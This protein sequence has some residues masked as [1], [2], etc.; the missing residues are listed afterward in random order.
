VYDLFCKNVEYKSL[1]EEGFLK[2]AIIGENLKGDGMSLNQSVKRY[3]DVL[4]EFI[5]KVSLRNSS[6]PDM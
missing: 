1:I 2:I 6:S 3:R 4:I 5:Y